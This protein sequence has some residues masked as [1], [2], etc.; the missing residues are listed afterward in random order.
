M[1]SAILVSVAAI[2]ALI[3]ACG[4]TQS[5]G[6]HSTA[7]SAAAKDVSYAKAQVAKYTSHATSYPS[8]GPNLDPAKVAA[9][10]GKTILFV[11]LS[12]TIQYYVTEAAAM[13]QALAP[14]GIKL[15]T[16]DP[17]FLPS[18]MASCLGDAKADGAS[19]VVTD[20]PYA[21][22]A[23]AF[24]NL[25]AQ[26]IPVLLGG[27]A[28]FGQSNTTK[29]SREAPNINYLVGDM[30][31]DYIIANSNGHA[32]V[33]FVSQ[34]TVSQSI[35][36]GNSMMAQFKKYCPDCDVF[37]GAFN[38]ADSSAQLE[39]Q[40]SS[41]LIAHPGTNWVLTQF[42]TVLSWTVEGVESA[43]YLNK[44]KAV[45]ADGYLSALQLVKSHRF[46]TADIGYSATYQGWDQVDG[47][48]R[49]L[50]GQVPSVNTFD[51]LRVFTASNVGQLSLT[52][53]ASSTNLWYGSDSFEKMYYKIWTGKA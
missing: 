10:R 45:S 28:S 52:A 21:E 35:A 38:T 42:D 6:S 29:I 13:K 22:A 2:C 51:P 18:A 49:M 23:T 17:D 47:A 33:L 44:V 25:E 5:T 7:S 27:Q 8:P 19:L 34:S 48:L 20:F 15:T 40:V 32:H 43:G 53:A 16:C 41:D 12:E 50:T 36:E 24:K 4:S 9:L 39:S 31:V 30:A 46:L 11:P 1:Q 3:A 26:H 37:R 14:L